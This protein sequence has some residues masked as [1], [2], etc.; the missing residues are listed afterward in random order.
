[1]KSPDDTINERDVVSE[2]TVITTIKGLNNGKERQ[3]YIIF[4]SGPMLGK[5]LLLEEGTV[6]LGREEGVDIQ[7]NDLGIS[8]RHCSIQFKK[9]QAFLR[10]LGSTNGTYLNSQRVPEAEIKDGDKIQISSNTILKFA[11]QDQ[12][13]NI[14]QKELYKMAIVDAL[15]GAHNK[16]HFEQRIQEEFSYC[17]RNKVPLSLL[18]FDIDHFK[19]VNDT[20][21]HP[22]GDHVLSRIC[23]L[24]KTIIRNEDVLARIGGEEFVVILKATEAEGALTL[25]ERLRNLIEGSAFEFEGK[26]FNVTISIGVATLHGQNFANWEAMLKLADTLLYKSKDAGRNRVSA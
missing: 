19:K 17:F 2:Q 23:T 25:A 8:R 7:I 12:D 16:R 11:E 9:G 13:E 4:L 10:D 14:F 3:A 20:F 1:M 15:T 24:A 6:V 5:M 22:T 26:R 18:M 21:G